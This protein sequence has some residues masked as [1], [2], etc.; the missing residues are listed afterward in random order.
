M[1][2]QYHPKHNGSTLTSFDSVSKSSAL[3]KYSFTKDTR[4]KGTKVEHHIVGYNLP[5]GFGQPK[6]RAAGFGYGNRVPTGNL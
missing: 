4:F 6:S 3:Q 2:V 1:S 5:S